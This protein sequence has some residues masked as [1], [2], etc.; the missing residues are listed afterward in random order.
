MGGKKAKKKREKPEAARE[1]TI[2]R[3][4]RR[5]DHQKIT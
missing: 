5:K 3:K 2:G 1:K 4:R